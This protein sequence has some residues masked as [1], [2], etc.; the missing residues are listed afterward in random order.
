[1]GTIATTAIGSGHIASIVRERIERGGERLWHF[2]DFSDLPL[3]AVAK[4][5]SRLARRGTLDRLS[6]GIYFR[7]RQTALGKSRPN[8]ASIQ[9]LMAGHGSVFP[10]GIAAANLLGFTTQNANRGEVA[11]IAGS[12][13]RKLIGKETLIHTRRPTAWA[14]LSQADAAVLDVLR[15]RAR[16]SELSTHDTIRR[17][18]ALMT[19]SGR[20]ERL[21]KVAEFEPPRVRAILGAIG[22]ELKKNPKSLANLRI[23]LNPLSSFDFG[24]LRGLKHA[25]KWQA[26]ERSRN[27]TL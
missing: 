4:S 23:S 12:L 14:G 19:E 10:A 20:F 8:P 15:Q 16:T 3:A 7:A 11:T 6:K 27:E 17:M 24:L 13:P 22:Q 9:G 2:H 18:L 21:L 26:K 5:L 1:M 25:G